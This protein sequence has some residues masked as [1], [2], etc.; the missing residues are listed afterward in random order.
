MSSEEQE[1]N[2]WL[3]GRPQVI[4]DMAANLKPWKRYRIKETGQHCSL[5]SFSEDKTVSVIVDGHDSEFLDQIN[6]MSQTK[7]FGI[8]PN[9]LEEIEL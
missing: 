2:D 6:A 8:H 3:E 1:F 9:D 4:V 7:V 5:F